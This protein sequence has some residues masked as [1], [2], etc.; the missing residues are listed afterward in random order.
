MQ[1]M[2]E[3]LEGVY[4]ERR[5]ALIVDEAHCVKK[6]QVAVLI[7]Y[8]VKHYQISDSIKLCY[9]RSET[10]R[11]VLARVGEVRSLIPL[12]FKWLLLQQQPE[13]IV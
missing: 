2:E 5:K 6:W 7:H 10:F 8:S 1:E 3:S 12:P 11:Q 4:A 13:V 9:F